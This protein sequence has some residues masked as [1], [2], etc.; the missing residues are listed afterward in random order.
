VYQPSNI[1]WST[2]VV[3][4]TTVTVMALNQT[5][6]LV[7]SRK[8]LTASGMATTSPVCFTRNDKPMIRPAVHGFSRKP[9]PRKRI[10]PTLAFAVLVLGL[11]PGVLAVVGFV[12]T[13]RQPIMSSIAVTCVVT[14][15]AYVAW[16]VAQ[17][18]WAL[19]TKY[20]LFL[21]PAY[22]LYALFGIRTLRRRSDTSA[23]VAYGL[24]TVLI[25]LAHL[26]LFDFASS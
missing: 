13:L 17:E 15:I 19:K 10:S 22:V 14:L 5:A 3:P 25:V 6:C 9:Y 4:P 8:E 24:V 2:A 21:R 1:R 11:V 20:I 16:F 12:S 18:S 26:Y 7:P 23:T